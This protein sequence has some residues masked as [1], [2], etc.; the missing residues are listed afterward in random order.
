SRRLPAAT[1]ARRC[2][3][4]CRRLI[5]PLRMLGEE[6][7]YAGLPPYR[8]LEKESDAMAGMGK[9]DWADPFLLDEQL[10][11]DERMIRDT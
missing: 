3:S 8:I 6:L 2:G 1:C 11:E 4:D 10:S 5:P 7:A 9:F